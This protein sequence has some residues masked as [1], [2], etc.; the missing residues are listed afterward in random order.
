MIAAGHCTMVHERVYIYFEWAYIQ[1]MYKVWIMM[2]LHS[3]IGHYMLWSHAIW[4]LWLRQVLEVGVIIKWLHI[5][6]ERLIAQQVVLLHRREQRGVRGRVRGSEGEW[7]LGSLTSWIPVW[8]WDG[9]DVWVYIHTYHHM[10]QPQ[11]S[12]F[13][14]KIIKWPPADER[15][16]ETVATVARQP[17]GA[18]KLFSHWGSKS[19]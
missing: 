15:I 13:S 16:E 3:P 12:F 2:L 19:H 17:I 8:T 11:R 9:R 4:L 1:L 6:L 18:P 14:C 5:C 10:Y 7:G